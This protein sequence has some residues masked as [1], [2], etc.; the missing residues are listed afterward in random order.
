M[1]FMKACFKCNTEKPFSEFY[2][3]SGMGDGYLGKCKS[4]TKKD[5]HKHREDN[6]DKVK[7]YDRNRPNKAERAQKQNDYL[8]TDFG[9]AVRKKSSKNYV[10]KFPEKHKAKTAVNNA[11]RDGRLLKPKSCSCC[12]IE[13][14]PH[15]HHDDYSKPLDVRWLCHKCHKDFH[16]FIRELWRNL[17]DTG[18]ENPFSGEFN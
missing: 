1:G 5:A 16:L 12:G 14:N 18:I 15:G 8:K 3:H 4:C 10:S 13:C 6:I 17:K 9:K 7:A 2:R 11:I